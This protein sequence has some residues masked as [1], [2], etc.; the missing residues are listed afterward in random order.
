MNIDI[1]HFRTKPIMDIAGMLIRP[2]VETLISMSPV[3]FYTTKDALQSLNPEE[4]SCYK[5]RL[6][7]LFE[8]VVKITFHSFRA[9]KSISSM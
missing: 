1:L 4:R 6:F 9:V 8:V 7:R 2:G 5:A 3:K